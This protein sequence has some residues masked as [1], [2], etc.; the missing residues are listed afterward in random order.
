MD[1][2]FAVEFLQGDSMEKLCQ[3]LASRGA[4]TVKRAENRHPTHMSDE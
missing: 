3:S 1:I 4:G 2:N